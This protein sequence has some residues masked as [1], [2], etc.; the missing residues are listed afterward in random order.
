MINVLEAKKIAGDYLRCRLG[1]KYGDNVV[2][3]ENETVEKPYGWIFFYQHRNWIETRRVRDGFIGNGPIL[4]DKRASKF[5]KFGSSGSVDYWCG[6]YESGQTREDSDGVVHL[7]FRED[8]A[9]RTNAN[10]R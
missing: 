6:L 1:P 7:L 4:V 9:R 3:L 8:L 5:V 10:Q 2:I